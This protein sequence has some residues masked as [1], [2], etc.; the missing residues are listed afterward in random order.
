MEKYGITWIFISVENVT[1]VANDNGG[2]IIHNH[3]LYGRKKNVNHFSIQ[4]RYCDEH[5]MNFQARTLAHVRNRRN[6]T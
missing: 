1:I 6:K 3:K 4:K 5:S 2:G